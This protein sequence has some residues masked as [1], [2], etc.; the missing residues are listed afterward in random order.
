MNHLLL[1]AVDC[2]NILAIS[3]SILIMISFY[4]ETFWWRNSICF[5][6]H[7]LKISPNTEAMILQTHYFGVLGSSISSSGRYSN[8]CRWLSCRNFRISFIPSPSYL[9]NNSNSN[10]QRTDKKF[11]NERTV[12]GPANLLRNVNGFHKFCVQHFL[13]PKH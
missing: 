3:G 5:L 9:H 13:L 11:R 1:T 2:L 8:T 7:L 12:N 6:T 4:T 10:G